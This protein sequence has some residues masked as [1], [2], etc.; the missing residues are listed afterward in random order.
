[1]LCWTESN[2]MKINFRYNVELKPIILKFK[3]NKLENSVV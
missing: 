1:M 3:E 2:I